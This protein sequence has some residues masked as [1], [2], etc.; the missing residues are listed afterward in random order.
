MNKIIW[1]YWHQ[2]FDNAPV[3]VK[4]CL[5]KWKFLHKDWDIVE[6]DSA[7]ISNYLPSLPIKSE[8]QTKMKL[9]HISDLI[10]TQLLIKYGGVWADP[11][12][13]PVQNLEDWLLPNFNSGLFL[14]QNPGRDRIIANWFMASEK[15]NFL[16]KMLFEELC[17]FW[18][19]NSFKNFNSK[20]RSNEEQLLYRIIN[21]NLDWPL[22]WFNPIFIRTFRTAPYMVYHYKFYELIKTNNQCASIFNKMLKLSADG[23]HRLKRLGLLNPL[24]RQTK[25]LIDQKSEPLF[26]LDWKIPSQGIPKNSILEYSLG[27]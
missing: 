10:R 1:T 17:S 12:T 8:V 5:H 24:N 22:I 6:L 7:N 9:A 23:P 13:V 19:N 2:G 15:D 4:R 20:K 21:R 18:N 26:K 11:T 16:L 27:I 3:L 14:F 25:L